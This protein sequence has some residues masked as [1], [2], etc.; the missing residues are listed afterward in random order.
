[1]SLYIGNQRITSVQK[2]AMLG[3]DKDLSN[4]SDT[5][6]AK[7]LYEPFIINNGSVSSAG[8]NDTLTSSGSILTCAPCTITSC[9][10]RSFT[11]TTSA[12]YDV[13][14]ES[15]G[16]YYVFKDVTDGSLALIPNFSISKTTPAT[17]ATDDY[18]LDN[19]VLPSTLKYYNSSSQWVVDNDLVCLGYCTVTSGTIS[20]I[21]NY[22]FNFKSQWVSRGATLAQGATYPKSAN[23]IHDMSSYLPNDGYDYEVAIT[24]SCTT[25]STSGNYL[26]VQISTDILL[27]SVFVCGQRA[28]TAATYSSGGSV[29][30]PVGAGRQIVSR[31]NANY[32]GTYNM[33]A[34]GYRR[35]GI[36]K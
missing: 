4:L 35:I 3:A 15:N 18:W 27:S 13:S 21:Y 30:V 17:P 28:R 9:D 32:T 12:A 1:M 31:Y 36:G 22:D 20:S 33:Y 29:I 26:Y 5:G 23:T 24:A 2:V 10:G 25:G 11:D 34:R 7:L 16:T 14:S 6:N 8:A 19:S